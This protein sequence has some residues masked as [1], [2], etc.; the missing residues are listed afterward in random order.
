MQRMEAKMDGEATIPWKEPR[1]NSRIDF[2]KKM[3]VMS[4]PKNFIENLEKS[5]SEEGD[6]VDDYQKIEKF[7]EARKS[8]WCILFS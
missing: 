5:S 8:L 7:Q 1:V 4:T 3:Q 2:L 6:E